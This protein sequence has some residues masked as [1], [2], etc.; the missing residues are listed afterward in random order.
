MAVAPEKIFAVLIGINNYRGQYNN[1]KNLYGCVKDV[2]IID[3]LLTTTLRVP[4]G[5]VHTL[6][7]PHGST[8]ET[9]PTK[10][11]VLA[12]IEEVAGRAVASGPGALFFLH[13]SGHGM[14]TK[15][16]YHK[17]ENGGLKSAGA[18]DEGLCTL[19]EP[20]MDVELSNILDGLNELGLTVFVSLD[21]CHSGG[22]DRD[23][24]HSGSGG[25]HDAL[26]DHDAARL[27]S[28]SIRCPFPDSDSDDEIDSG[29]E[30][31]RGDGDGRN[32][33][34][35]ESWLYRNRRHNLLAACQPSEFA[36][37][38]GGRGTMTYHLDKT[39]TALKDSIIPITYD[40]LITH[41][42]SKSG[43][44]NSIFPQQPMLLG[45]RNRLAFGT[46]TK[47]ALTGV[48][49]GNVTKTEKEVGFTLVT[50]SRGAS[51]GVEVGDR[52]ALYRPDQFTF[53][54]LNPDEERAAEA[55]ILEVTN[56]TAAARVPTTSNLANIPKVGWFAVLVQRNHRPVIYV[57]TVNLSDQAAT[58]LQNSWRE[59]PEDLLRPTADLRL[60]SD[61]D[62]VPE[63]T[64]PDTFYVKPSE[65]GTSLVVHNNHTEIMEN[66]PSLDHNDDSIARTLSLIVRHL[67]PYQRLTNLAAREDSTNPWN[68]RYEFEIKRIHDVNRSNSPT[69][70]AKVQYGVV[71]KN[72]EPCPIRILN[73]EEEAL[74]Q[75]ITI[76]NLDPTYGITQIFPDEGADSF[77]VYPREAIDPKFK[78][79]ITV[80]PQLQA[81]SQQPGF[82]MHDK[83][84]VLISSKATNFRHYSQP[85][86]HAWLHPE[87]AHEDVFFKKITPKG[88]NNM[89][90][91]QATRAEEEEVQN[92][93]SLDEFKVATWDIITTHEDLYPQVETNTA[94]HTQHQPPSRV[95]HVIQPQVEAHA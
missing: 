55:I 79:N 62:I 11:N 9:L 82:Q 77:E 71:F 64:C 27:E 24:L 81:A 95:V 41:L 16:I 80:P 44:R 23:S 30:V 13:Y 20:L 10:T 52:F 92:L 88:Q 43:I 5:N 15:T 73:Q 21:C 57:D 68:P 17:P 14:R 8:P 59:L 38:T 78:L 40:M 1:V 89:P 26:D 39:L 87:D 49:Q 67:S 61:P 46:N 28:V 47:S 94:N 75:F 74:T 33:I 42:V 48:M 85:D 37:E 6:T 72:T 32:V 25:G 36:Y 35:Q 86:L 4:A 56:M 93:R 3:T 66:V 22:A 63:V 12:L 31:G 84:I 45:N 34:V 58:R 65:D 29:T 19:G 70:P 18:Y 50:I 90:S 2:D 91:R 83:I 53:G 69:L 54:L 7:S 76:F 51:H 60:H